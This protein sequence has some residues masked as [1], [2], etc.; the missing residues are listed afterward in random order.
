MLTKTRALFKSK[1]EQIE[2]TYNNN[3]ANKF[4]QE[5][6]SIIKEFNPPTLLIR[7]NESNIVSNK[8]K[9]VQRWS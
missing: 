9:V 8:E 4:C 5:V 3:E 6:N 7:G 1:L 2:S